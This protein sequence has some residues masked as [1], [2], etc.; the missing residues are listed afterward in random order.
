MVSALQ[1]VRREGRLSVKK[2]ILQ[3]VRREGNTT[4]CPKKKCHR[5]RPLRSRSRRA[6][7]QRRTVCPP[8]CQHGGAHPPGAPPAGTRTP[9]PVAPTPLCLPQTEMMWGTNTPCKDVKLDTSS[10]TSARCSC[11][12]NTYS[13]TC[14]SHPP[15]LAAEEPKWM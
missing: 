3:T 15:L 7:R 2:V 9:S 13:L 5:G 6:R 10:S 1:T 8:I 12:W 4:D 14:Q 11:R